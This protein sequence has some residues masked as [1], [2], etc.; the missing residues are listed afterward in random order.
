MCDDGFVVIAVAAPGGYPARRV[1]TELQGLCCLNTRNATASEGD[2]NGGPHLPTPVFVRAC[3]SLAED[4]WRKD[5]PS[6]FV[7]RVSEGNTVSCISTWLA[8][9]CS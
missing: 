8:R 3:R 1:A 9:S 4:N 7:G 2:G 5:H 6:L